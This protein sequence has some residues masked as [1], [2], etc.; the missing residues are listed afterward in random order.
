MPAMAAGSPKSGFKG[1]AFCAQ[2]LG[3]EKIHGKIINHG[4]KSI[5]DIEI[6]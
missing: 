2:I 5:A 1:S 3:K 4:F 6:F